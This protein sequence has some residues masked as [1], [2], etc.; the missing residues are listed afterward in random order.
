MQPDGIWRDPSG[1][2]PDV[3]GDGIA[4]LVVGNGGAAVDGIPMAGAISV[5]AGREIWPATLTSAEADVRFVGKADSDWM[6]MYLYEQWTAFADLD[7]DGRDDLVALDRTTGET[8]LF[9]GRPR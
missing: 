7:A 8:L 3:D 1:R 5:F 2:V 6:G 9:F 4:D